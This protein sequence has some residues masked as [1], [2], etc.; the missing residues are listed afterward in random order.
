MPHRTRQPFRKTSAGVRPPLAAPC[1]AIAFLLFVSTS[2]LS[3]Q[4]LQARLFDQQD[5]LGNPSVTALAQDRVG[6]LWVATQN[7][8]FRYDGTRF[9][10][11][12]RDDGFVIP[13]FTS[14]LADTSGTLWAGSR[15][16]LF[17]WDGQRF[18]EL[19]YQ[20]RSLHVG[21]N[22]MLAV[23]G[24]GEVILM[25]SKGPLSITRE[26][27][28]NEYRVQLYRDL[29]PG[30]PELADP[31]GVAFDRQNNLWF[32]SGTAICEYGPGGLRT[33]GPAEGVPSDFYVSIFRASNG[34]M[35]ARGRKHVVTIGPQDTKVRD[36][37]AAFPSDI[38]T[39]Y[40]RFA[41][42]GFGNIL[43]P[44]T[45]GFAT[46]DGAQWTESLTTSRGPIDGATALLTDREG[47]VWI[48]TTTSGLLQTLGYRR[49]ENYGVEE[50]LGTSSVFGIAA[51]TS[52]RMWFGHN[53]GVNTLPPG[54]HGILS[55][56][57]FFGNDAGPVESLA[58][59]GDGGMWTAF[60]LGRILHT[61][62]QHRVDAV[63]TLDTYIHRIR[64]DATGMLWIGTDSGL[65]TASCG[66]SLHCAAL[67]VKAIALPAPSVS[68]FSFAGTGGQ[69]GVS[70]GDGSPS[71]WLVGPHGLYYLSDGKISH[72]EVPG[73]D[74]AFGLVAPAPDGSLWLAGKTP[75]VIRVRVD[76]E[77][78]AVVEAHA[79]PE[80]AS[81]FVEFMDTDPRGRL[82]VGTDHGVNV[83]GQGVV[84]SI[85][86]EDGLI[87]NDTDG[88]A[89]FA[90]PD[91]S[92]WIG[93][94]KGVSHLLDPA[95]ILTRPA[96]AAVV[97]PLLYNEQPIDTSNVRWTGGSTV[98]PFSGLTFRDN[99][100]LIYHY[101]LEGFDSSTIVTHIPFVRF[102][103]LP[104]GAYIFH[105][106]A[107]D[108]V[109]RVFSAPASY[110]FTLAPPWW[111]TRTAYV[112]LGIAICGLFVLC[113]RW[114]HRALLAQRQKLQRLVEERTHEL[115]LL[116]SRDGLTGVLNRNAIL[117]AL[118]T[119]YDYS[120]A[121]QSAVCIAL[122]DLDHFK[123]VND[124]LGHLA[125]DEVLRE[126]ALRLSGAIRT[127]DAV[128]RYGGEEFLIIFRNVRQE[129]GLERCEVLRKSLSEK[130]VIHGE[131]EL[132]I[133]CSIGLAWSCEKEDMVSNLLAQ[134][135]QA[136]Y[137]AKAKGRNRVELVAMNQIGKQRL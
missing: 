46:W 65:F 32:G 103:K 1:C 129:F 49:W 121:H 88:K 78:A 69:R 96:F 126:A 27:P 17:Y 116:A 34:Q 60:T 95:A 91:G 9:R 66:R 83:L 113:W 5:G 122:V 59:T 45:K 72:I 18:H 135:D 30:F 102:Q 40:R 28:G 115:Q 137:S 114:S 63:V 134:A 77:K 111:R 67:P 19:Q 125:G 93:T 106:V 48:G 14:L 7:G 73:R 120:R 84:Y 11:F 47:A 29:H 81:D 15:S 38:N 79:R 58:A 99:R 97:E 36:L 90:S 3:G 124:T 123:D 133:T 131:H 39:V 109:H 23:S 2:L 127:T 85:T 8:L 24:A 76:G 6:Y 108:P 42:D 110:E 118:S 31:N 100:S 35:W 92:V 130:P 10:E 89:F 50:G 82:W 4:R 16:G 52:G 80:L 119:E 51:D 26:H 75:G 56:N 41:E 57:M 61:N 74:P 55:S 98:L 20:G 117:A 68:D 25:S 54:A 71:I 37:T 33:L 87:W 64:V 104:P 70:R 22:S 128:G 13:N 62:S 136:M 94:G 43:A 107:E 132:T 86:D 53:L 21:M 112:M 44:T 12:G 101:R 105:V